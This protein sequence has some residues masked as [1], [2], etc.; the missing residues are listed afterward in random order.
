MSMHLRLE[1]TNESE[2]YAMLRL[3]SMVDAMR[4]V[5][6]HLE[7]RSFAMAYYDRMADIV[8]EIHGRR[9]PSDERTTQMLEWIA[10]Y[11]CELDNIASRWKP[12]YSIAF[13]KGCMVLV[14]VPEYRG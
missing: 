9:D 1:S 6:Q 7:D 4:E 14:D 10:H 3:K 2:R 11:S 8:W 13:I 5:C 12:E